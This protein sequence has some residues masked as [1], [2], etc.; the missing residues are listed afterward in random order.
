LSDNPV[1]IVLGSNIA[2]ELNLPRA[3]QMIAA[4]ADLRAVSRVYES[5]PVNA[6]GTIAA[7]Q[8]QFLNAAVWIETVISPADLKYGVL[9]T[10]EVSLG[11]IRTDDKFA[12]RTIDLDIA[13]YGDRVLGALKLP[14]PDILTR[15]YIA[16]PLADLAPDFRHP[17]TGDTLA[18]IAARFAD[19]PGIVIRDDIL[20]LR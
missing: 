18:E 17:L 11:R 10:I 20:L 12:P 6:A 14:D 15:A 9:R 16:L 13:L 1:F 2:P 4:R 7:G 19:E 5:A 8:G 3:V